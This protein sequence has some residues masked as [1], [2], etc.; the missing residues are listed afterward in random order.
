M[1]TA[2]PSRKRRVLIIEPDLDF[3]SIL[4]DFLRAQRFDIECADNSAQGIDMFK[5][6][7]P[8]LVLLSRELPLADG[9]MG[10]DGLRVLKFLKKDSKSNGVPVILSSFEAEED[11]FERYRKL[12]FSADD[13]VK[14]PFEDT[15]ILRRIENFVGFDMSEGIDHIHGK[16][17]DVMDDDNFTSV[18]DADA[19][20]L[21]LSGSDNTRQEVSRLLEQVGLELA[22]HEGM[23]DTGEASGEE[24]EEAPEFEGREDSPAAEEIEAEGV[25]DEDV[26]RLRNEAQNLSRS[27]DVA[28]KQLVTERKRSREIK[29][30]W[31]KKLQEIEV[32]LQKTARREERMREEFEAMRERFADLELDHTMEIEKV[33]GEKRRVEEELIALRERVGEDDGYPRDELAKDLEKV[34]KALS[35]IIRKYKGNDKE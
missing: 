34:S 28:Q 13:Y 10:P 30:E 29:R 3:R 27:L 35:T 15:D 23:E 25:S 31:K 14:K 8:D 32:Q 11:D 2:T 5:S 20:E 19:D 12:E 7:E 26:R 33:Q 24:P 1:T 22:R 16:I 9:E 4:A 6:F 21:G 17:E 18:F